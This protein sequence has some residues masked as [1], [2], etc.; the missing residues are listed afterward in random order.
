MNSDAWLVKEIV[1]LRN[2]LADCEQTV[3]YMMLNSRIIDKHLNTPK[4]P[5]NKKQ[6]PVKKKQKYK[7]LSQ[8]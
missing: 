8:L 5:I 7:R 1:K 6:K 2:K 4:Q 3:Q